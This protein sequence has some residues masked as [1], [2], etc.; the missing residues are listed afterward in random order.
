MTN[1]I[2][3]NVNTP[4]LQ[5]KQQPKSQCPVS[6]WGRGGLMS[7]IENYR[8]EHQSKQTISS[9]QQID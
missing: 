5:S 3:K 8:N 2:T 7:R 9:N 4:T 1:E 6:T